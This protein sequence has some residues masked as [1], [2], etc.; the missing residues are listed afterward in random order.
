MMQNNMERKKK[1]TVG[2][3]VLAFLLLL[4]GGMYIFS[5]NSEGD[6]DK[7]EERVISDSIRFSE[8]YSEVADNNVFVYRDINQIK[9]IFENGTGVVY[10][11]F[12]ECPWCQR[13]VK[14]LDEV[15]K[16]KGVEKIFYFNIRQDRTDNSDE[17]QTLVS[18]L[19]EYLSHD[20]EGNPR[21]YVP[22]ISFVVAGEVIGHDN[23]TSMESGSVDEYWTEDKIENLKVRL[24]GMFDQMNNGTCTTCE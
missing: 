18:E 21:I 7:K 15:A 3:I 17:Y 19:G 24:R 9:N 1:I 6:E 11:G 20:D 8:E 14:Y 22:D 2:L 10:L 13:Y 4:L 16:E 23:E 5:K 12:P